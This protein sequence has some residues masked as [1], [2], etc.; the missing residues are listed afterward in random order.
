MFGLAQSAIA[1]TARSTDRAAIG[2]GLS[3]IGIGRAHTAAAQQLTAAERV[4][5]ASVPLLGDGHSDARLPAHVPAIT[6]RFWNT[7]DLLRARGCAGLTVARQ[8]LAGVVR[9]AVEG[10]LRIAHRIRACLSEPRQRAAELAGRCAAICADDAIAS[11]ATLTDL[12]RKPGQRR[13]V[14]GLAVT[15]SKS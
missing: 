11:R 5:Q 4:G 3:R 14:P 6:D 9:R 15:A 10:F 2:A 12:R 1:L 13:T 7:N 8:R